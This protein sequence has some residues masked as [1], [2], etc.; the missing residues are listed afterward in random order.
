MIIWGTR[1][2]EIKKGT[3]LFHCPQCD[4]ERDYTKFRVSTYFTL[5]FIPLFPIRTHGEYVQ[6]GGCK[7]Q[8][9]PEVLEYEPPSQSDRLLHT[10]RTDLE[11][12]TPLEMARTKLVNQG[13][14]PDVAARM[15]TAA[16]GDKTARCAAC[17]LSFVTG[18]DRC[19]ACGEALA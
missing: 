4:S 8:F 14:A 1:G 17:N 3:G 9:K 11:N 5:Y 15:I 13:A 18:I 12:G 10:I 6:C 2:R 16:A 7:G 19:S